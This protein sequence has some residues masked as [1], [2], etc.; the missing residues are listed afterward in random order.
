MSWLLRRRQG[1]D[2]QNERSW[3]FVDLNPNPDRVV[4]EGGLRHLLAPQ[5]VRG[6]IA[7]GEFIVAILE[8]MCR[9]NCREPLLHLIFAI[10]L[11]YI[12]W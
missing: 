7:I 1:R 6:A 2:S 10:I 8:K 4:E 5:V 12:R 9:A 3:M 11:R